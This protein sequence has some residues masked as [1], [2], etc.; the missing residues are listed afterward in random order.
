MENN[1]RK[2]KKPLVNICI[3]T[4]NRLPYTKQCIPNIRKTASKTIPYMITVVDNNSTDGTQE[5]LL[6]LQEHGLIDNLILLNENIGVAKAQNL[7]WKLSEDVQFYGKVDNDVLF[8]KEGWLDALI[9]TLNKTE[10]IG[11][12]GY[13][14]KEDSANYHIVIDKNVRYRVKN[15]NIG[16]ACFFVPKRIK[17]RLGFWNEAYGK[18]GEEDADYGERVKCAGYRNAYMVDTNVMVHLPEQDIEYRKFKDKER[19]NN[20]KGNFWKMIGEYRNGSRSLKVDTNILNE[21]EYV[22][23]KKSLEV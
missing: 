18:Y 4:F 6:T 1:N 11:A 19:E 9:N 10:K 12:L 20:L 22:L 14:C 3:A 21:I 5:H 23:I 15:G 8:E 7:G 13:Q 16:G 17:D 2:M